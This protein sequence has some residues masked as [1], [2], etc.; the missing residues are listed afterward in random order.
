MNNHV[1]VFVWMYAFVFLGHVPR[2]GIAGLYGTPVFNNLRN[3]FPKW[4]NILQSCQQ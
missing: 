3:C 4:L 2:T 1:Q